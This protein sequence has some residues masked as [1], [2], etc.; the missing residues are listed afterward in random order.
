MHKLGDRQRWRH[1]QI[2][3]MC[4]RQR[5]VTA[6][7]FVQPHGG[8]TRR[9]K[10]SVWHLKPQDVMRYPPTCISS[11]ISLRKY[12]CERRHGGQTQGRTLPSSKLIVQQKDFIL[13]LLN[14]KKNLIK[15]QL[16]LILYSIKRKIV[17]LVCN[18]SCAV[19]G[20]RTL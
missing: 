5:S 13:H 17:F 15:F 8:R 19:G 20:R 7:M 6:R 3:R 1:Q 9:T 18:G 2:E 16:G 14:I 4:C 11:P 10:A 12:C